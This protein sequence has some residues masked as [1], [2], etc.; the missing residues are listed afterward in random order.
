MGAM[1]GSINNESG[2]SAK[3][4]SAAGWT[5][6]DVKVNSEIHKNNTMHVIGANWGGSISADAENLTWGSREMDYSYNR[7]TIGA[8]AENEFD[9]DYKVKSEFASEGDFAVREVSDGGYYDEG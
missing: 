6:T 7:G 5:V 8:A 9:N 3:R 4:V 2:A 1:A